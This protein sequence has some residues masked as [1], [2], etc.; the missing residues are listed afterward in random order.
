MQTTVL[1]EVTA[2]YSDEN[3]LITKAYTMHYG[4]LKVSERSGLGIGMEKNV[5][6]WYG[7]TPEPE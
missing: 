7:N 2:S 6:H 5:V 3:G 1:P 4:F